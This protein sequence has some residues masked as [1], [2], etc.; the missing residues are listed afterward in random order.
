V[1]GRP[2]RGSNFSLGFLFLDPGRRE[3]LRAVY[4]FCR[5]VDDIVDQGDLPP[6]EAAKALD[7]WT[8]E[9][10]RLFLGKAVHPVA[11]R[12]R[13]HVLR[14]P[15]PQDAFLDVISGVRMDLEKTRYQSF[16]ELERYLYGVAGAVGRLCVEI[17][18]YR[19]TAPEAVREYAVCLGN[20]FQLTNILRD[21]GSDLERGRIYLPLDDLRESG[22]SEESILR[23]E[24]TPGFIRLMSREHDRAKACYRKA[25]NLLHPSDRVS[26]TPAEVMASIYEDVLDR[27]KAEGFRVFFHRATLSPGRKLFLAARAWAH[28]RGIY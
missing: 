16:P 17:F 12:L 23:R 24:H 8:E 11:L 18:G 22:C 28:A 20:A 26:M 21:V 19:H 14:F 3:A 2:E 10:G 6:P 4:A 27:V 15:L 25:R 13:P 5:H 1:S 7:F 9:I